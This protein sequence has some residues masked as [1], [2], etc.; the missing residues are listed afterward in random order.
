VVVWSR[1]TPDEWLAEYWHLYESGRISAEELERRVAELTA[2]T[3]RRIPDDEGIA[4]ILRIRPELV[5]QVLTSQVFW[6]VLVL[7]MMPLLFAAL[8][9]PSAQG[10]TL[11]FAFLWFFLFLRLFRLDLSGSN[12]WDFMLVT[13]LVVALGLPAI[14]P[15]LRFVLGPFYRLVE[16]PLVSARWVGFVFGVGVTEELT[17]LLPVLLVFLLARRTGRRISLQAMIL[18]GIAAGLAFGGFE[19]I[20]YS[21]WFGA[22]ILGVTFARQDVVLSRLLMTPFLH[23]LWAGLT[24]FA[25][26]VAGAGSR[27]T[28]GRLWHVCG[29]VF[30]LAA[31]LHGSY[32]AFSFAPLIAV[33]FGG[34]SYLLLVLAVMA[35]KSWEGGG[36]GFLDERVV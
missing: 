36:P 5:L 24:A 1:M 14:L 19:N 27:L 11:Y 12:P 22:R 4:G 35:A 16:V 7:A 17:K 3:R 28:P 20:L 31:F 33:F 29:P 6:V 15:A 30:A 25:L 13:T 26:G 23:S 34:V 9:I 10:M 18:A 21:N 32:D 2:R 8:G